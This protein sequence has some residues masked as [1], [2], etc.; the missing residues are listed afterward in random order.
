MD[1]T[2]TIEHLKHQIALLR[3]QVDVLRRALDISEK[4][5]RDYE[6]A[7]VDISRRPPVREGGVEPVYPDGM[8]G[9]V[10]VRASLRF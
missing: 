3:E 10:P 1:Q 6:R 5:I 7:Q 4:Q 8:N 9:W 2:E